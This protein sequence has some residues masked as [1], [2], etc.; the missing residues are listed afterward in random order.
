MT[1]K[2]KYPELHRVLT[3]EFDIIRQHVESKYLD[4]FKE[5]GDS[6]IE[7]PKEY[8]M[9]RLKEEVDEFVKRPDAREAGDILNFLAMILGAPT[10]KKPSD[11]WRCYLC[12][13]SFTV[14]NDASKHA[15]ETG[16]RVRIYDDGWYEA[17]M[18]YLK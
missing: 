15:E 7:A 8:M 16:H 13:T 6:W 4:K 3:L 12:F 14:H 2:D 11:T 10:A 1:D 5:R 18:E 9:N 17:Q